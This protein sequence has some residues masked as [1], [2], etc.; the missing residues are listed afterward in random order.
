MLSS[1]TNLKDLNQQL[2]SP[3]AQLGSMLD[4]QLAVDQQRAL[5]LLVY[6]ITFNYTYP[7]GFTRPLPYA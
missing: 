3:K 6:A 4:G 2:S 7:I 1:T 5:L